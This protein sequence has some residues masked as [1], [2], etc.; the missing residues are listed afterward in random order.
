MATKKRSDLPEATP[1]FVFRGTVKKV[2]AATMKE[3]PVS[4]RTAVV[5]VEQVIEAPQSF[6]HYEGQ[7]I[8]VGLAGKKKVKAGEELVFHADSWIFG[9]SIAVQAVVQEPVTKAH[10]AL[11]K[12]GGDPTEHRKARQLQEHLDDADLVVS[13]SV[14][15]VT[16]PPAP[17]TRA[18]AMAALPPTPVSEHDAKWRQAVIDVDETYKGRHTSKQVTVLFPASMDVR[19]YKAPKFQAGQKGLFILHKTKLKTDD[20]HE[21][22]GLAKRVGAEVEVFTALHPTDVH[23]LKQ[24]SVI[25]AM[26]R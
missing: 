16:V 9:D 6:A 19:W 18:R 5:R 25:R 10:S 24:R 12:R 15:A 17:A 22:R 4:D 8:T 2:R 7:D 23:P 14:A 26:I 11:L 3:V 1:A 20:H 21:L 13:G